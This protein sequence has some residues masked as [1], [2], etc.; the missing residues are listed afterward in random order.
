MCDWNCHPFFI[1]EFQTHKIGILSLIDK[2]IC[3]VILCF[4]Q[5]H[6]NIYIM[7][8]YLSILLLNSLLQ[9]FFKIL[10]KSLALFQ[11]ICCFVVP[12]FC[13]YLTTWSI[14]IRQEVT[15]IQSITQITHTSCTF[16]FLFSNPLLHRRVCVCLV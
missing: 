3:A 15:Y 13:A 2:S 1:A 10:Y 14:W 11:G 12:L 7:L 6:W 9:S 16:C 5:N 8:D 4:L